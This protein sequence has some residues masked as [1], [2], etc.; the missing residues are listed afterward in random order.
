MHVFLMR[1]SSI[2][3]INHMM[4]QTYPV[5]ILCIIMLS[6]CYTCMGCVFMCYISTVMHQLCIYIFIFIFWAKGASH[7]HC[8]SRLIKL[9]S[10][11]FKLLYLGI[12]MLVSEVRESKLSIYRYR[13]RCNYRCRNR[14]IVVY[15]CY[16]LSIPII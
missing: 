11:K 9:K 12:K 13:C 5:L 14:L 8:K 15:G 7:A 4:F 2:P 16:K 10:Q 6:M 1:I 3:M